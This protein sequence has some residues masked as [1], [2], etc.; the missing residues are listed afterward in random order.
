M[1]TLAANVSELV[2]LVAA[3]ILVG[4]WASRSGFSVLVFA[5]I[6]DVIM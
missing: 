1:G 4:A 3:L 6:T 2:A 5:D